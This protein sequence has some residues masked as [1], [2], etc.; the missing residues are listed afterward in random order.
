MG[1]GGLNG[2]GSL[3]PGFTAFEA[4]LEEKNFYS[5]EFSSRS[6][7]SEK[8]YDIADGR[9][10]SHSINRR[11]LKSSTT[12]TQGRIPILGNGQSSKSVC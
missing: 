11:D 6:D 5:T 12:Y 2:G 7:V 4:G 3:S 8:S 1:G 10:S 9:V